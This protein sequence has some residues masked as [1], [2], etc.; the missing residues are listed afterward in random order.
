MPNSLFGGGYKKHWRGFKIPR[1]VNSGVPDPL[2]HWGVTLSPL[3]IGGSLDSGVSQWILGLIDP[4]GS[5]W[6]LGYS[7]QGSINP[8]TER[9]GGGGYS[10]WGSL[11]P[12]TPYVKES[13]RDLRTSRLQVW[14]WWTH[15][16]GRCMG[17]A[18][19]TI[20][21]KYTD[22]LWGSLFH[23]VPRGLKTADEPMCPDMK[24]NQNPVSKPRLKQR[25]VGAG[26]KWI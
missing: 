26:V 20:R 10:I 1:G 16:L 7:D 21:L 4:P 14:A 12:T 22:W 8:R 15:I 23:A 5:Q 9:P 3:Y 2:W 25:V 6:F 11:K 18:W 19:N 17:V 13:C 24:W